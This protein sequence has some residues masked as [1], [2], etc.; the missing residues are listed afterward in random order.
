MNTETQMT[1]DDAR[2][3]TYKA[4]AAYLSVSEREVWRMGKEGI[5]PTIRIGRCVRFDVRDLDEWIEKQ[6]ETGN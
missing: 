5:I 2:L 3:K 4:T 6:K 1:E